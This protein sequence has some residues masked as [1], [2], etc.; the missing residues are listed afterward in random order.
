MHI[1][2]KILKNFAFFLKNFEKG[3]EKLKTMLYNNARLN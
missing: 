1:L 2:V 3:I